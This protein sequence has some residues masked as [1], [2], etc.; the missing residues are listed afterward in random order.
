[1]SPK[2]T[3]VWDPKKGVIEKK[4]PFGWI[5]EWDRKPKPSYMTNAD[6]NA[7]IKRTY[8]TVSIDGFANATLRDAYQVVYNNYWNLATKRLQEGLDKQFAE[9]TVETEG[10][11]VPEEPDEW[12]DYPSVQQS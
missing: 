11:V 3:Y 9:L 5:V 2:K 1:M 6:F 10:P 4:E 8:T 12:V 7:T